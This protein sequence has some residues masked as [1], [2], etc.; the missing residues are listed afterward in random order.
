MNWTFHPTTEDLT[1]SLP[2]EIEVSDY[3]GTPRVNISG[4][5]E[6]QLKSSGPQKMK[7]QFYFVLPGS[8][9]IEVRD[10]QTV[11]V[12]EISVREHTYLDFVNEF[13]AFFVL[14]LIVMGG[15]V[16]WTRRIMKS[17]TA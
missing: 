5:G 10:A 1:T 3:A 16:L 7:T 17:R 6:M 13:G 15:I 11:A 12:K 8:Y 4:L 9:R 2:M 14:F